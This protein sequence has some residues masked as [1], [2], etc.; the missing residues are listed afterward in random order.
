MMKNFLTPFR[1]DP[2][3]TADSLSPRLL[4]GFATGC[5]AAL[6]PVLLAVFY[7]HLPGVVLLSSAW[8]VFMLERLPDFI[9]F[10]GFSRCCDAFALTGV[11]VEE[12]RAALSEPH[13]GRASTVCGS[14]L[15]GA[16]LLAVY[17]IF[18][19]SALFDNTALL[20]VCL[21][22]V[23]VFGRLAM[24]WTTYRQPGFSVFSL[25][26]VL[27][28]GAFI[29]GFLALGFSAMP[30]QAFAPGGEVW[31]RLSLATER[32]PASQLIAPIFVRGVRA[33]LPT[34]AGMLL[35]AWYWRRR[36]LRKL[37]VVTPASLGAACETAEL[38]AL[39]GFLCLIETLP[40]SA[41]SLQPPPGAD[42][43][44]GLARIFL[45]VG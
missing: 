31:L 19:K 4:S 24:L 32:I 18:M 5:L 28:P 35:T 9:P 6:L 34:F 13:A 15:I 2:E 7:D 40:P 27:V 43:I 11:S 8:Y 25:I 36:S 30:I 23:P 12:R 17:L 21:I 14:L 3:N 16:K 22:F 45:P 42:A 44:A 20:A 29:F 39:A 26:L 41:V 37:G 38:A 1:S 10:S 33:L